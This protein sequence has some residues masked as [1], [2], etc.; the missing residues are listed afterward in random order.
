[1][2]YS[3][4]LC[5]NFITN[6]EN[7]KNLSIL[8]IK[9]YISDLNDFINF[10]GDEIV[11]KDLISYI[12]Y[13]RTVKN[14]KDTSIKRKLVTISLF[15]N[16]LVEE[17]IFE[18]NPLTK[19]KLNFKKEKRLPKTL[20]VREVSKILSVIDANLESEFSSFSKFI[21]IRD[22]AILDLL[23]TTGI[24]IH[25]LSSLQFRDIIHH[26]HTILIHGKGRKQRLI[27]I[28]SQVTWDRLKSW[29]K[30]RKELSQNHDYVFTNRYHNKISIYAIEDIYAKYRNIA[31]INDKS[32]PHYLRHT[33]A[34]NLL[35]NGADIR[36]VQE[37]L[38]H[39]SITTTQIYT[40]VTNKRKK[41]VL[42][43]FNYRN[44]L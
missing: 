26:D 16:Y 43:K 13:L 29:L 24:R 23:I 4:I 14:L 7:S 2:R 31:K 8:T 9:A 22:A 17:N 34:T 38:G 44:K 3:T 28:S 27:Y 10:D 12:N 6:I 25:E 35:A 1:M 15:Y 19:L 41:Q 32:T 40:E 5:N 33:F 30:L 37:I 42:N 39:S 11:S 36:A 18:T 20:T 21:N